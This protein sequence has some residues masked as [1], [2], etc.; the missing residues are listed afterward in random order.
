MKKKNKFRDY[1][2]DPPIIP[3]PK[4]RGL[5]TNDERIVINGT[6]VIYDHKKKEIILARGIEPERLNNICAY[7]VAEGFIDK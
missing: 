2:K 1:S 7:L 6:P 3:W 5:G 4:G